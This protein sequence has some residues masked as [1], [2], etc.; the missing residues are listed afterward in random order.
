M[1]LEMHGQG[2]IAPRFRF[3][4][5]GPVRRFVKLA[6]WFVEQLVVLGSALECSWLTAVRS[7]RDHGVGDVVEQHLFH[8]LALLR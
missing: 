8:V 5:T 3:L 1:Q 7:A 6:A 4:V 2:R